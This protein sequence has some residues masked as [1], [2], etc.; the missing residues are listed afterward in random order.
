MK[1]RNVPFI[2]ASVASLVFM[3][4]LPF[5]SYMGF[6]ISLWD[7]ITELGFDALTTSGGMGDIALIVSI[8]GGVVAVVGGI[9][10]KKMLAQWGSV[11]GV[12]GL[13]VLL[14]MMLM[15]EIPIE[16]MGMGVWLSIIGFAISASLAKN[17]Q[18]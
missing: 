14:I 16:V 4:F 17:I 7:I 12:A 6:D 9:I 18:E 8:A 5:M 10:N 15:E 3:L 1:N 11:A 13:V 2:V